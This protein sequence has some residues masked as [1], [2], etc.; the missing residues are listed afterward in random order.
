[1]RDRPMI[2]GGLALLL[3][4]LTAP[5]WH[6]ALARTG[7]ALPAIPAAKGAHCVRPVQ[8]MRRN[9]MKLLMQ[10]RYQAVHEGIRNRRDS[11]PGCM[12]CHVSKLADGKY[13]SVTSGKF[14]CNACHEYVGVRIDCFSC[15]SNR[16]DSGGETVA[17]AGGQSL[18]AAPAA[19]HDST[20]APSPR[21]A[22]VTSA[23]LPVRRSLWRAP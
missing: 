19:L 18:L 9:H 6:G 21:A 12:S 1:M 5:F 4:M 2:L 7:G 8:W 14:F 10:V 22:L 23:T 16:P 11:L 20:M 15:H 13:P 17:Q 3:V